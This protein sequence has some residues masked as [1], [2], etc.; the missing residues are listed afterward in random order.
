MASESK[1]LVKSAVMLGLVGH[2]LEEFF[3]D[4]GDSTTILNR[5]LRSRSLITKILLF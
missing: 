2:F 4:L 5:E 3:G 1:I